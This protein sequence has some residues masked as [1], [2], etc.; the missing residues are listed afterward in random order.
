MI[1]ID[2]DRPDANNHDGAKS[3]WAVSAVEAP[4]GEGKTVDLV[5]VDF[6]SHK[7]PRCLIRLQ[8]V[9]TPV[10]DFVNVIHVE[11]E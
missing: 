2:P 5:G 4:N 10:L 7:T 6:A 3:F 9:A 8:R 1:R 11:H